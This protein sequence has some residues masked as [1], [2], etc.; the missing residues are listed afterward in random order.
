MA[1]GR[2][3]QAPTEAQTQKGDEIHQAHHLSFGAR[4][5]CF[6]VYQTRESCR[7][8]LTSSPDW[9]SPGLGCVHQMTLQER[10]HRVVMAVPC[11][12][13]VANRY[14]LDSDAHIP[15]KQGCEECE[16]VF[17]PGERMVHKQHPRSAGQ[18]GPQ[19]NQL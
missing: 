16:K 1:P 9:R 13:A 14:L 19:G 18:T 2:L 10:E 8:L 6:L 4:M 11:Q 5:C 15:V 3:W 7:A 17:V 12:R